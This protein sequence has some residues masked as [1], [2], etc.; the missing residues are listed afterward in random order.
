PQAAPENTPDATP[1]PAPPSSRR[2]IVDNLSPEDVEKAIQAI[3]KSFLDGEVAGEAGLRRAALEGLLVRLNP[4]LLVSQDG[5]QQVGTAAFPY[6]S[7]ILDAHIGYVR[8]GVL[9]KTALDQFDA[10]LKSFAEKN[11]DALILDLRGVGGAGDFETAADFA[12][13]LAPRGKLLFTLQKPSAKQERIFTSNQ[14]PVFDEL[15][16]VLTDARTSGPA[17]ALAATLRVNTGAMVIGADTAGAAVELEQ[18]TLGKGVT[19]QIAVAQ[20][21]LPEAGPLFPGGLKP[22]I[23]ISLPAAVQEQIFRESTEKGVSQFVFETERRR[24]NEASL[25]ANT[26][27]EIESAQAALRGRAATLPKDTILQRAVDLVTAI[28]FYSKKPA[29][30]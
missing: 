9:D 30:R 11:V 8:P 6:L 5:S 23:A 10:S 20:V 12:R 13:R 26:N 19:L 4:G 18:F 22:D 16:V 25:V 3:Q 17:E 1:T 27:P 29:T 14:D 28:Q 7:E 15:V 24:M 2:E 21:L